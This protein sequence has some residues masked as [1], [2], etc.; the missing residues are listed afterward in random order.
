MSVCS[1]CVCAHACG[2]G[3]G[4]MD[5]CMYLYFFNFFLFLMNVFTIIFKFIDEK[6]QDCLLPKVITYTYHYT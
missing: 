1:L 5:A 2:G 6:K 4:W 3:D